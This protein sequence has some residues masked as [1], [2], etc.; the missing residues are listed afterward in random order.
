MLSSSLLGCFQVDGV[1]C[2]QL[3]VL[4]HFALQEALLQSSAPEGFTLR[5]G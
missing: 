3:A 4:L 1:R 5:I 2:A